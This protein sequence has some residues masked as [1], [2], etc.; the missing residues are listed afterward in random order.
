MSNRFL[1]VDQRLPGTNVPRFFLKPKEIEG[2]EK[3]V[4]CD[5]RANM[6]SLVREEGWFV[7]KGG[8]Y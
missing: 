5:G 3:A 2:L 1:P 4:V 8:G 6:L 7:T